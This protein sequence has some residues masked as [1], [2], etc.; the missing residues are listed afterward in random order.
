MQ[1]YCKTHIEKKKKISYLAP[2]LAVLGVHSRS[3]V[4]VADSSLFVIPYAA[5]EIRLNKYRGEGGSGDGG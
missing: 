5:T 1:G 4:T 3:L 2:D